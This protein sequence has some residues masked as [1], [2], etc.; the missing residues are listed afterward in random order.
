MSGSITRYAIMAM[1][2]IGLGFS[3][4]ACN[5]A[6]DP[7]AGKTALEKFAVGE[8]DRLDFSNAG[9]PAP[10]DLFDK[11]NGDDTS[12]ATFG[13]KYILVNLWATWCGPC[14]EEMP[15]L[16]ALQTARGGDQFQ[17][18]PL[19]VDD[20]SDTEFVRGQLRKLSGGVLEMFI[21]HD[22]NITYSLGASGFPT[23]ILYGPD[24][25]EIARLA[26]DADWASYE[27]LAF[28]DAVTRGS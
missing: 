17:V 8:M 4:Y 26:G 11:P 3:V 12:L 2:L 24:G 15:S 19:S 14:E 20:L 1:V 28:V 27:A 9:T 10:P 5:R 16:A 18:I 7:N 23:T 21:A 6:S 13:G 25:K 22:L